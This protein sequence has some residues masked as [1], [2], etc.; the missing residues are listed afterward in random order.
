[1]ILSPN[2]SILDHI[3]IS[4]D[5]KKRILNRQRYNIFF[6]IHQRYFHD[7][8]VR[9]ENVEITRQSCF[10]QTLLSFDVITF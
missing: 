7:D 5:K 3:S 6:Q 4:N 10:V 1:M 8:N 2:V 9:I